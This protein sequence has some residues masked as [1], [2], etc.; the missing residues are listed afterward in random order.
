MN[1]YQTYKTNNPDTELMSW[2]DNP[3]FEFR[4]SRHYKDTNTAA[5]NADRPFFLDNVRI[6]K[7]G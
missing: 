6:E 5:E 2:L 1:L 7:I 3:H 4:Y